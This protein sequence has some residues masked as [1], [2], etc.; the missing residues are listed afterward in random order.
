[1]KAPTNKRLR[2]PSPLGLLK[3]KD[4]LSSAAAIAALAAGAPL[5]LVFTIGAIGFVLLDQIARVA[6]DDRSHA[7]AQPWDRVS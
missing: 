2:A 3:S 4:I 6:A 7:S 5:W 1:M